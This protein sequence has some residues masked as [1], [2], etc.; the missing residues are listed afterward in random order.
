MVVRAYDT[1]GRYYYDEPLGLYRFVPLKFKDDWCLHPARD[2]ADMIRGRSVII[3]NKCSPVLVQMSFTQLK[4]TGVEGREF[5]IS[6]Y[7]T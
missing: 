4:K 2:R 6:N 3:Y 1:M 5:F 7:F